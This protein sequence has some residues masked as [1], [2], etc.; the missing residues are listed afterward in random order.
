MVA[1]TARGHR[2]RGIRPGVGIR[3]AAY[4]TSGDPPPKKRLV[5][6]RAGAGRR[7]VYGVRRGRVRFVAV[8]SRSVAADRKRLRAHLRLARLR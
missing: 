8:V 2:A 5:V 4:D 6:R 7:F 1:S 3:S